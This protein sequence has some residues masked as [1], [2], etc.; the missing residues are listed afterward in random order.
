VFRGSAYLNLDAKGR[1][2]IPTKQRERLLA[3]GDTNLILTVDRARCLLLFPVQT[4][5]LI[6]RD[7]AALPAFD[8]AAR[9]VQRLYLGN[10]EELE[11]DAQGRVLLPQHL[12]EFAFLDKRIVLVGQ[13]AKFEIW[14]EQRWKDKTLAD[15]EDHNIGQLAMSS[16]LG[17]LKF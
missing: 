13:G 12:R 17:N 2:A 1:F 4:W 5:E 11:M 9:S 8:D 14:D 3:V 7:L 10:A 6:E 15:L 16:S